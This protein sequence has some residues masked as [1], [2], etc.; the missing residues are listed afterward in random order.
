MVGALSS[1][2]WEELASGRGHSFVVLLL[3]EALTTTLAACTHVLGS[4]HRPPEC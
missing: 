3:Q 2:K 4:P 1:F